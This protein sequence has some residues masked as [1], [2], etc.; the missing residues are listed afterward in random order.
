MKIAIIGYGKMGQLIEK[1]AIERG[2]EISAKI[3]STNAATQFTA[4]VIKQADVVIEFTNPT[5]AFANVKRC[6]EWGMPVVS[7]STGWYEQLNEAKQIC[8]QNEAALLTAS[9]FSIGVHLFW[10]ITDFVGKLMN[11]QTNYQLHIE[12]TH[13]IHKKDAPS[14]TAITTAEKLL[15]H[16]DNY[17]N[18]TLTDHAHNV[19]QSIPIIAHRMDEVP[20]THEVIFDNEIDA[21]SIKHTAYSRNGFALGAVIAAEFLVDKKGVYSM[22]D[23]IQI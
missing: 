20:G 4:A 18:W 22:E 2:H 1:V 6:L 14:G 13:H 23:V 16:L 15:Q 12:E 11:K 17:S 5:I 3:N 7:G 19:D 8:I 21:L 9:N 10:K